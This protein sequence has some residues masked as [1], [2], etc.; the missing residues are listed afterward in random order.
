MSPVETDISMVSE[1]RPITCQINLY[2]IF[3]GVLAKYMVEHHECY[4]G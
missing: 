1:F 2:K 3:M 4:I